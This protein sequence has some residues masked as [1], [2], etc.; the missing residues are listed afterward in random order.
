MQAITTHYLGPTNTLGPRI[1]AKASAGSI[2]IPR[3]DLYSS[4][5]C[6]AIAALKL[7]QKL[8]WIGTGPLDD[9]WNNG[10]HLIGDALP[11]GSYCWVFN[12]SPDSTL[13]LQK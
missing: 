8:N 6:H 9:Q 12:N 11:D 2:T 1:K 7:A 10:R 3:P 13:N 4:P 5:D